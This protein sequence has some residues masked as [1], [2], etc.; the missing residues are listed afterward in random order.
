M[1]VDW[2][3]ETFRI[4]A[5]DR[6]ANHAPFH[7]DLSIL[8][9]F[10]AVAAAACLV[11]VP[12]NRQSLGHALNQLVFDED[13][14]I[15][16]SVPNVLIRMLAAGNVNMLSASNLRVVLFAG[17]VFPVKH[18]RSLRDTL[19][20][21]ELYNLYGPTET[22]VCTY[23]QV[24]DVGDQPVPIGRACSYARTVLLDENGNVTDTEGELCVGGASV[25]LGYWGDPAK[26]LQRMVDDLYRTGDIVRLSADGDLVFLGRRDHMVKIRGNRIELGEVEAVLLSHPAVTQAA[27]VVVAE[28]LEAYVMGDVAESAIRR[29]CLENLPRYM[30]PE[31]VRPMES[32]PLTSTG[33]IDRPALTAL[34][35]S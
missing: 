22:N 13:I 34:P 8:D 5:A 12:E 21:M 27:V 35:G 23:Y 17:E 7:F 10:A 14:T 20:G 30:V 31:R 11:I 2:A 1:F 32:L 29:H 18:L 19:P 25:M 15:W 26:T 4:T 9:I 28:R 3:V 16:Y 24:T 6:L 33:K